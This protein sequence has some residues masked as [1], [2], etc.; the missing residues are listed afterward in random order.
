M[1]Q[2]KNIMAWLD[3][4]RSSEG[5][6]FNFNV[7]AIKNQYNSDQKEQSNLAIKI[8]SIFGGL[9][10]AMA[11]IGFLIILKIY[12]SD[13]EVVVLGV[14][15]LVSSI[16]LARIFKKLFI[17]TFAVALFILGIILFVLGLK[18]MDFGDT[19]AVFW[20]I[21]ISLLTLLL[22]KNYILIFI[23][24]VNI[25]ASFLVFIALQNIY[26]AIHFYIALYV[27]AMTCFFLL[28]ANLL[29]SFRSWVKFYDPV[30][31]GLIFCFLF[32]LIAIGKKDLVP[33]SQ[34]YL[35][36]SS[37]LIFLLLMVMVSQIIK[38]LGIESLNQ[39]IWIYTLS[40]IVL[41]PTLYAPS[42]S[43]ALLLILLT[44]KVN[45]KTG[46]AIGAIALIYFVVQYYYDLNLSLLVKSIILFASGIAFLLLY[47]YISKYLKHDK[48]V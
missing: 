13:V 21:F 29:T 42:I 27:C 18:T 4:I 23:S 8:L 25:G 9:L 24:V 48:K 34:E 31:I 6:G 44:Y 12:E 40:T 17:D 3:A 11:F 1:E 32:G 38:T 43:G 45:Y 22:S 5:E 16:I 39:K 26:D 33:I 15:F 35:W 7:D 10:A 30:R 14:G 19:V 46:F 28:E 41:L 47:L 36:I 37:I 2:L 20:V